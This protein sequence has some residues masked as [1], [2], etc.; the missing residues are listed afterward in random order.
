MKNNQTKLKGIKARVGFGLVLGALGLAS[1]VM[2]EQ[3]FTFATDVQ[4]LDATEIAAAVQAHEAQMGPPQPEIILPAPETIEPVSSIETPVPASS[5]TAKAPI[6]KFEFEPTIITAAIPAESTDGSAKPAEDSNPIKAIKIDP[7]K[8]KGSAPIVALETDERDADFLARA[9][10]QLDKGELKNAFRTLRRHLYVNSPT[11][12]VL[13]QLASIGR[14]ISEYAIAEQALL[15]AGA[16]DPKNSEIHVELARLHIATKDYRDARMAARQ[17]IRL[18]NDNAMAWNVAGR[19]AMLQ[20]HWQ[21]AE[22][23]FR[24]AVAIAPTHPM[25][26]NNLGLLYVRMSEGEEAVDALEAAV[27]LFDDDAPYFVYNN[28]GLAYEKSGAL[29]DARDAFEQAIAVNPKYTRARLN[30]DRAV[31]TL[32]ELEQKK[33]KKTEPAAVATVSPEPET[34]VTSGASN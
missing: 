21:R 20:Y 26:Y 28:L 18:D 13:Y 7:T 11:S 30:L 5:E 14:E 2:F 4:P 8:I 24:R 27:E 6:R 22:Q 12:S 25:I 3:T 29:E 23:A 19:V 16:L 33:E 9:E 17:A 10:I 32:A 1:A 31:I 15:D 34:E